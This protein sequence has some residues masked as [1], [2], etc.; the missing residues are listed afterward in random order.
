[1]R[2]WERK[3]YNSSAASL[4]KTTTNKSRSSLQSPSLEDSGQVYYNTSP[5][6]FIIKTLKR[7]A[8][9]PTLN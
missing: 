1:M 9:V 8:R 2:S 5:R 7:K 4:T 6:K 3:A